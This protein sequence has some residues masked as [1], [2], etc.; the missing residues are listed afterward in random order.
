MHAAGWMEYTMC[1]YCVCENKQRWIKEHA[2]TIH[3]ECV[4]TVSCH[5]LH[6]ADSKAERAMGKHNK[7]KRQH[8]QYT[9]LTV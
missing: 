8:V 5:Y 9:L 7:G 4:M 6:L 2:K 3:P 1:N